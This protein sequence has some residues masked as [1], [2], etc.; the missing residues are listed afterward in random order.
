MNLLA[1]KYV[2]PRKKGNCKRT[3]DTE[4]L[5]GTDDTTKILSSHQLGFHVDAE[6]VLG[7]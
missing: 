1:I 2:Q 7:K 3:V 4:S 6:K 5:S